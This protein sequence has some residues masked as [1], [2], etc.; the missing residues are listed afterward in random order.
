MIPL[1]RDEDAEMSKTDMDTWR[2]YGW[3][4]LCLRVQKRLAECPEGQGTSSQT[5]K[6]FHIWGQFLC[7]GTN[8]E[9]LRGTGAWWQVYHL[10]ALSDPSLPGMHSQKPPFC[11]PDN[12]HPPLCVIHTSLSLKN[13]CPS[14]EG[15]LRFVR[16]QWHSWPSNCRSLCLVSI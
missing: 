10:F 12:E 9:A 3:A 15:Q 16:K 8:A 7:W 11:S 13:K 6:E 14:D 2:V 1:G 4:L 5:R